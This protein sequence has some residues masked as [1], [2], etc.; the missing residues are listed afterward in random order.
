[1]ST[2]IST[3]VLNTKKRIAD[4]PSQYNLSKGED[5]LRLNQPEQPHSGLAECTLNHCYNHP[6]AKNQPCRPYQN[7]LPH[8]AWYPRWLMGR[9]F[10]LLGQSGY[11]SINLSGV[12][13][14][15]LSSIRSL[16]SFASSILL[17]FLSDVLRRRKL[18]LRACILGMTAALLLFPHAASFATLLPIVMLYSIFL[19]PT[20]AI[21]DENTLRSLDNPRDYSKVRMG[22]SI[23]WGIL[24]LITGWLLDDPAVNLTVIFY[25]HIFFLILLLVLTWFLP[26]TVQAPSVSSEKVSFKDVWGM[27]RLPAFLPWMGIVFLWGVSVS[28]IVNFSFLHIKHLGGSPSLMGTAMSISILGEIA[29]F[30][31]AKRIQHKVGSR[32]MMVIAFALHFIWFTAASLIKQ[33]V[34]LLFFQILSGAGFS[35]IHAGSVAYVYLRAP[36]RIGTTAQA[37]RSAI[38]FGLGSS[39]GALISGTLYQAYGSAALY[40]VM[41]FISLSGLLLGLLLRSVEHFRDK[42]A[43]QQPPP[44]A[45]SWRA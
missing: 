8:P 22:G 16:V 38:Q 21:L 18:I 4:F 28:S 30:A 15:Q 29:G 36:G 2:P 43:A 17:A 35:L 45:G 11:E 5:F 27:L 6:H 7:F 34:S 14:G 31:A 37:V 41:S 32:M 20:N 39:V 42:N 13:I 33:P 12:Q 44:E 24:V 3:I 23:G 9:I 40:R 19:S 1:M 26:E 10:S 25:L